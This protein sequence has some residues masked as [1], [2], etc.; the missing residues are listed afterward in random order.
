MVFEFLDGYVYQYKSL[1]I[2]E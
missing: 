1:L 2:S